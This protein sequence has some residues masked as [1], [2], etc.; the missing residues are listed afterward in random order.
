MFSSLELR[1]FDLRQVCRPGRSLLDNCRVVRPLSDACSDALRALRHAAFQCSSSGR[2]TCVLSSGDVGVSPVH[3]RNF[4][5][6]DIVLRAR[7]ASH[8][9]V[10]AALPLA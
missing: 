5:G 6:I 10:L 7:L 4:W 2:L 8:L 3:R 1:G 9:A